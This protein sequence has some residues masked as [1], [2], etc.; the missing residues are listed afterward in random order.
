MNEYI[1]VFY[2]KYFLHSSLTASVPVNDYEARKET[3]KSILKHLSYLTEELVSLPYT[4]TRYVT[5]KILSW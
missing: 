5:R 4:T 2:R 1:G 3:I